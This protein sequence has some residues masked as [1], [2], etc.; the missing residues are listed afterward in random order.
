MNVNAHDLSYALRIFK[1]MKYLG[2]V[3]DLASYNILLKACCRAG[4][5]DLA[6]NIYEEARHIA[7]MG[8]LKLDVIT[9]STIIKVFADAKMWQMAL[10]IKEDML[11]AGVIPNVVTWSSLI[12]ACANAG[13]VEE[14]T[15][16][17]KE[18]LLAS[19]EPNSQCCNS[20]LH[21]CVEA[22]QYDRAFRIFQS[23]RRS[24]FQSSCHTINYNSK[25]QV[26]QG[27]ENSSESG[28]MVSFTPTIATFNILMKACGTDYYR[29]KSLM[30]E[31]KI[32]GLS[33]NNIT[34]SIFI[35]ICGSTGNVG[36]SVQALEAMR[37]N[38]LKP[39]VVAYTTAIKACVRNKSL[40]LAFSLFEEMKRYR[41]K[42]NL[43]TY[44]TILRARRRYGS[45][46]EVQQ[47]LAIYQDMRKEGY[48]PNDN[49]LKELIEEWCEGVITDKS[50]EKGIVGQSHSHDYIDRD[51]R[52]S[53][54]LEKVAAHL[55]RDISQSLAVD[56]RGLTKVEARIVVLAVLRM[57]KE[58]Y[59]KGDPLEDDVVIILGAMNE[60]TG[61]VNHKCEVQDAVLK[62]LRNELGLYVVGPRLSLNRND[63][64]NPLEREIS[65][66]NLEKIGISIDVEWS[67]RRP[68]VLR[69]LSVTRKSLYHWLQRRVGVI[70]R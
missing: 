54:L 30:D 32:A 51:T 16:I 4:R 12:S 48:S 14:A 38:G 19:C 53:V 58:N 31:I 2:V 26:S 70:R 59:T 55:E 7:M 35:D 39:D 49:F 52:Q 64:E 6:K 13:L 43:V 11:S 9:Y 65:C 3:P 61:V 23:W 22:C 57:I 68:A 40:K 5:V 45:V 66:R 36:G 33:P 18:M 8:K 44:K 34:W 10:K 25:G 17:F 63:A 29:A 42:P 27:T 41:V 56:L 60:L 46:H 62:L 50:L 28:N 69:R 15:Q 1:H 47:C 21:A 37:N 67:P 20:L 24:D